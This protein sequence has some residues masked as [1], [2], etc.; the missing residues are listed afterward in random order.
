MMAPIV[1]MVSEAQRSRA[2]LGVLFNCAPASA[3]PDLERSLLDTA[4]QL[5]RNGRLL[6]LIAAWLASMGCMSHAIV[7]NG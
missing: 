4:H 7:S 1:Q 6:P 2:R 5:H 3:T